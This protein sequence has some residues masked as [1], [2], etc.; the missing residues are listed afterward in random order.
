MFGFLCAVDKT[1]IHR[2]QEMGAAIK[3]V[4][5]RLSFPFKHAAFDMAM[6][7]PNLSR[8]LNHYGLSVTRLAMLPEEVKPEVWKALAPFFG[9]VVDAVV[10]DEV[11]KRL[12][13][14]IETERRERQDVSRRLSEL[15]EV[16]RRLVPAE[17]A[18]ERSCA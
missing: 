9:V 1:P 6:P 17:P 16:I 8:A 14:E 5:V 18:K 11:I 4:F 7:A 12:E 10:D 13:K 3:E 2:V 15:E